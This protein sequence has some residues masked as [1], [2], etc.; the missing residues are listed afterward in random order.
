M[1]WACLSGL[2][3]K[4]G[5]PSRLLTFGQIPWPVLDPP[6]RQPSDITPE[7]VGRFILHPDR[8]V[9]GGPSKICREELRRWHPD[10]FVTNILVHISPEHTSMVEKAVLFVT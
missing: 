3:S 7:R 8:P 5:C 6:P 10:K 2:K 4:A 1:Q 9:L